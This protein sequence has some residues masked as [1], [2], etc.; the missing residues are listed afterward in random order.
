[1]IGVRMG[2]L[3]RPSAGTRQRT[4]VGAAPPMP[5]QDELA[6]RELLDL[7]IDHLTEP[8]L[9]LW[10]LRRSAYF[11]RWESPRNSDGPGVTRG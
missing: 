1:M 11:A 2:Q 4:A 5:R 7:P 6:S 10:Q 9:I 8:L 3:F